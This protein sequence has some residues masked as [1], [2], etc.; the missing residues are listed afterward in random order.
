MLAAT[1]TGRSTEAG[2][3]PAAVRAALAT[4]DAGAGPRTSRPGKT[5][6]LTPDPGRA[7]D[8][9]TFDR[10]PGRLLSRKR[11][12]RCWDET[13]TER[14]RI[15]V[16]DA[17]TGKRGSC[18]R[19]G[20]RFR[21]RASRRIGRLVACRRAVNETYEPPATSPWWSPSTPPP[22]PPPPPDRRHTV[23]GPQRRQVTGCEGRL[24]GPSRRMRGVLGAQAPRAGTAPGLGVRVGLTPA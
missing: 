3:R 13:G 2:G 7:L 20:L 4:A 11:A 12:G 24:A 16:I 14:T 23:R 1:S 18:G 19:A 15:H 10:S 22:P 6:D 9:Q 21:G 8:E 5:R 17:A